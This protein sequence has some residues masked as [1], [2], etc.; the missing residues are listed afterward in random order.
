MSAHPD[1]QSTSPRVSYAIPHINQPGLVQMLTFRLDDALIGWEPPARATREFDPEAS[2]L[3]FR[4][5]D[6]LLDEGRGAC[7]LRQ[8]EVASIMRDCLKRDHGTRYDLFAWVVMP[9]HVHALVLPSP[10]IQISK[11]VQ[12]WKGYSAYAINQHLGRQ[13]KLWQRDYYDRYMRNVRHFRA[14]IEY[15]EMN[16]VK[17]G[18]VAAPQQYRWSSAWDGGD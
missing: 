17:A 14:A 15:I 16:P 8:A 4:R 6:E 1:L 5:F 12:S 7:V 13:G 11:I 18:L 10:T 2:K 9:N 3:W